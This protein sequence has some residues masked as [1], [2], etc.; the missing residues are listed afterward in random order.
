MSS[1]TSHLLY[2][3]ANGFGENTEPP[4]WGSA[5]SIRLKRPDRP[6]PEA[7]PSPRPLCTQIC[8][9]CL[10]F[11][12]LVILV[13]LGSL[14][15]IYV[16]HTYI[17]HCDFFEQLNSSPLPPTL[18]QEINDDCGQIYP[19]RQLRLPQAV[20]PVF[21]K[22]FMHPNLTDLIFTG[23]VDIDM[24]VVNQ[25]GLIVIHQS[26]LKIKSYALYVQGQKINARLMICDRLQQW[27]FLPS[28]KLDKGEKIK[29]VVQF[30]GEIQKNYMQGLYVNRHTDHIKGFEKRSAVTQFEPTNARRVFPCFD[31]PEF[32]AIFDVSIVR[33]KHHIARANTHL[34]R[35]QDYGVDLEID[36]FAPSLK[37]S[38]YILAFAV[39]DDFQKERMMTMT[40]KKP[41][42]VNLFSNVPDIE[43]QAIFGLET[44]VRALSYF[45]NYFNISFPLQ[46]TDLLALD[47]FAEGAME[48]WGLVTFRDNMLLYD[49]KKSPEKSKEV[50]ALVVCHEIA[51]QWF[52]N[53]VTMKWWNDLWLNEGF[54]NYMEFLCVDALHPD[55]SMMTT[56]FL[57]NHL[58]STQMDGFHTSH[59]ISTEVEDPSQIT[60]LFDAI[61]YN[62][63]RFL[64]L[65]EE[66]Y[67]NVTEKWSIPIMYRSSSV[68]VPRLTWF[69]DEPVMVDLGTVRSNWVVA[70][71]D[72]NGFYRVLYTEE[73]YKEFAKQLRRDHTGIATVDRAVIINDAFA[74]VKAGYLK[75]DVAFDL[76]S[77][78]E[79]GTEL[80][81]VPWIVILQ[82]L[83][84][85][86]YL[87]DDN[88]KLLT[89]YQQF[90]RH[91]ILRTYEEIGWEKPEDHTA[92]MFQPELL[93]TA[94]R[95]EISNCTKEAQN[96]FY[97]WVADRNSCVVF[98]I[99]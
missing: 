50:I 58:Y 89:S 36:H 47:D 30:S 70:N 1:P 68:S 54:A 82:N 11:T 44:T 76:V 4:K 3:E 22:L 19:W 25:T 6:N 71:A 81:R 43:N 98:E 66:R 74:F 37:M 69:F 53:Y 5:H 64:Y 23:Q 15:G 96:R 16:F 90:E 91:L 51:H 85:I 39:L 80:D 56:Y 48:N 24:E 52:G 72:A 21:Y 79:A 18:E 87:I 27:A 2:D 60:S 32:K 83:R 8:R 57:D 84:C 28:I 12:L 94:C 73:I 34:I 49:P 20:R 59:S 77:Y 42:E 14:V 65:E 99:F 38:T 97:Q 41:I 9:I 13:L 61:S 26:E 75:L 33:E 86:E 63:S 78:V 62:K 17:G 40:T 92:K 67:P 35:T 93:H 46:K 29:M 55:W 95:L 31:E 45:E 88:Y 7:R 10:L